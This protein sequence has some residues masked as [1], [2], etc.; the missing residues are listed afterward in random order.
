MGVRDLNL[1]KGLVPLPNH[2]RRLVVVRD[3]R[4]RWRKPPAVGWD[5][6]GARTIRGITLHRMQGTLWGTDAYYRRP[7]AGGLTD[8]GL[9]HQTGELLLWN[10]PASEVTPRATGPVAEPYGDGA[11]FLARYAEPSGIGVRV[12]DRDRVGLEIAGFFVQPGEPLMVESPWSEASRQVA[13]QVCAHY[14]HDYGIAWDDYPIAPDDGFSFL[15]WHHE[16]SRGTGQVCPGRMV[17][18][19]TDDLIERTRATL[20]AYQTG[21]PVPIA[22]APE[23]RLAYPDGLSPE[24]A[25]DL[26]GEIQTS[27]GVARF[28]EREP[29]ARLW[30]DLGAAQMPDR[31]PRL[32]AVFAG[33]SARERYF[34]FD[35]GLLIRQAGRLVEVVD[36]TSPPGRAAERRIR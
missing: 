27:D 30:L 3:A 21:A 5:P 4:G 7:S 18:D 10:D 32:S 13:A 35:G 24:L 2:R 14:A 1:A 9:D 15:T 8:W 34:S 25:A 26:F 6:L 12:A 20:K 29:V 28:D 36:A 11:A 17:M 19:L 16:L 33:R 31:Y 23:A 22:P